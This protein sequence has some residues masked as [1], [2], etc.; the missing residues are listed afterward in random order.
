MLEGISGQLVSATCLE[1]HVS[2]HVGL[3]DARRTERLALVRWRRACVDLGPASSRRALLE[4][5]AEPLVRVL[6][7]TPV[8]SPDQGHES[9]AVGLRGAAGTA[10]LIVAP[11]G[12]RLDPLWRQAIVE[13]RQRRTRWALLFNGTHLRV[14]DGGRTFARR[15]LEFDLDLVA[16]EPRCF[17][18]L[19]TT[20]GAQALH[21]EAG[22]TG[23]GLIDLIEA[24]DRHAA[25]VCRSLREGVLAASGDI[26]QALAG[27]RPQADLS[28]PFDQALTIVYRILFL[29]FAEARGLVPVWHPVYR[30]SYSIEA[31][32]AAAERGQAIGLWD[33]L[34]AISRLA[35]AG[36]RAGDLNVTAFNG[37]LF[38]HTRVPLAERRDL[39]D[40]A[41]R[42]SLLALTTRLTADRTGRERIAYG[43]LGVEQ[44]GTVYETLLDFV[45][46]RSGG[47]QV[48]SARGGRT[49][50]RIAAGSDELP[51]PVDGDPPGAPALRLSSGSGIRKSTGTFYTPQSIARYLVRQTL[52]PLV[53]DRSP[54]QILTIRILDPAMG[55]GAFLVEACAFLGHAYEE[56]LVAEGTCL[57]SDLGPEERAAIKRRV[58]ECC[59]F[60]VDLNPMAVQL[61]R[62]SLWLTSL[63]HDRPLSFFD[64]HLRVG[65]SLVG[66]WVSSLR[67][68]PRARG[69]R[70]RR[71]PSLEPTLFGSDLAEAALREILPARFKLDEPNDTVEAVR[72]KERAL[73]SLEQP[74]SSLSKWKRVADLWC[75]VWFAERDV[76]PTAAFGSLT[77]AILSSGGDLPLAARNRY[78]AR[79]SAVAVARRFFHWEL[80]FPEVF[81]DS[82]GRRLPTSGFDAIVGNPPWDMVRADWGGA[83]ERKRAR[84][85]D[86]GLV[87]FAREAGVYLA[88]SGGH[89]NRYQLFVERAITLLKPGGR[90]GLVV[91]S[92]F[93]SDH[94]SSELRRLV[95]SR[96]ALE[97]LV[98]FDNRRALF[99]VHRSVRFLLVTGTA[100]SPT[101][102]VGTRLGEVD[103]TILESEEVGGHS[104]FPI[105]IT[106]A[107]IERLSGEDLAIPD[108]RAPIDLAIAERA[109]G[110]FP[111]LGDPAGWHARFGRELN[112]SDDRDIL[113]PQ[114]RGLPVLE[115]KH[116]DPFRVRTGAVRW[117]AD[118]RDLERR[119]GRRHLRARLAYR[120]VASS[121][122]RL[123]L[124]AA[125]LP[126]RCASTHTVFCLK[127]PLPLT[128]QYLLCGLFNSFVL[129]Y[130]VRL[131]VTTHV[132]TAIVERLPVPRRQDGPSACQD[133]AR[134]ARE[135]QRAPSRHALA[136]LNAVVARLYRLS[137]DEF[138]H[139]L[140][141]LP[142][143]EA[144]TRAEALRAFA[145]AAR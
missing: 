18:A 20:V 139:V 79:A 12:A 107:L 31:L 81:F 111:P 126:A 123:T 125:M 59:L 76:V 9:L 44:L 130:L 105:H 99:P 16:D 24:S 112:A 8:G 143:V 60:G 17:I 54:A 121:T 96:C 142:L 5:G 106:P 23:D 28:G 19:W 47:A 49:T 62:L 2:A 84:D 95:F 137:A 42:R 118:P 36:C 113:H 135:L 80:E 119:L 27:R 50:D 127:T 51:L 108:L 40:Q 110:L 66:A 136:R 55:S 48:R 56:A 73:A 75:A 141:T 10:T 129:N 91:P 30:E 32:R 7:F 94:G 3:G 22:G 41:A 138:A 116:I 92:G 34:R 103:A 115:G 61:A 67:S 109:A 104:W 38:D 120:D 14:L 97:G 37:R 93:A 90:F 57:P 89:A 15:Y 65:D 26:L 6:G 21:D 45:P 145:D 117:F 124:I 140:A 53:R 64:H 58:A 1:R 46:R 74:D 68:A 13:T 133:I 39:D 114:G 29:L 88:R 144:D 82:D 11:W 52:A 69:R 102:R 35:H 43:D 85:D 4:V 100:G 128:G 77:D 78:L 33:G 25:T 87:R 70:R 132:T 63:A 131:R 134:L 86:A 83:D 71:D 122:N 98:G 101:V 72:Q